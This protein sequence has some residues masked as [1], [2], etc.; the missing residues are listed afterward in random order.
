MLLDA[1]LEGL[2]EMDLRRINSEEVGSRP[3]R[4]LCRIVVVGIERMALA[5]PQPLCPRCCFAGERCAGM[6]LA[7]VP[8]TPT[9]SFSASPS[10]PRAACA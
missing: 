2:F 7:A 4:R 9:P 3:R 1:F 5:N 8:P 6:L 10:R